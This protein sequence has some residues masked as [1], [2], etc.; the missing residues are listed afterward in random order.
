[1]AIQL[2]IVLAALKRTATSA[3]LTSSLPR[4][5]IHM[6]TEL[7]ITS[8]RRR[9]I[10]THTPLNEVVDR[11][12]IAYVQMFCVSL[13]DTMYQSMNEHLVSSVAVEQ[14]SDV[15]CAN[16]VEGEKQLNVINDSG[17]VTDRTRTR[18]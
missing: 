17:A 13:G 15:G 12:C 2:A 18:A 16:L 1:M 10:G 11:I 7:M 3:Q 8:P 4:Y 6:R 5:F 14:R 9:R